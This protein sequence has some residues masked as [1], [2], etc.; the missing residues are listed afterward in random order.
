MSTV[1]LYEVMD[2]LGALIN[3]ADMVTT[4]EQLQELLGDISAKTDQARWK[5][6]GIAK[7]FLVLDAREEAAKK[8]IALLQARRKR[9]AADYERLEKY[10]MNVIA[11]FV[12]QPVD[13]KGKPKGPRKLCGNEAELALCATP[14]SV[15]ITD[16]ALV[17]DHFKKITIQLNLA[18]WKDLLLLIEGS[19]DPLADEMLNTIE[20]ASKSIEV[21][22]TPIKDAITA[23]VEV[24]GADLRIDGVRL[25][26]R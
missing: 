8:E 21:Q 1:S 24:P 12:Q 16:E 20:A 6:D 25:S 15:Q 3:S 22:L 7:Y 10:V 26:V 19:M 17:P 11:T 23:Q 9:I 2:D 18:T 13:K 5:I 4:D 14:T